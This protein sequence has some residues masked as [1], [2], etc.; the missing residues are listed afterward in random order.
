LRRPPV[1]AGTLH[2]WRRLQQELLINSS[3]HQLGGSI[4]QWI[5]WG[6]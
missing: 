5:S 4:E 2:R 1:Q 3:A 6:K